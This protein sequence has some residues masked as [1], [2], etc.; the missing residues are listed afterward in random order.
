MKYSVLL[1]VI[2]CFVSHL[3]TTDSNLMSRILSVLNP[4]KHRG[5]NGK[6]LDHLPD[7][8]LASG[9]VNL[10]NTCYMNSVL[11]SLFHSPKFKTAMLKSSMSTPSFGAELQ[12]LFQELQDFKKQSNDIRPSRLARSLDVNVNIQEDAQEFLLKVLN[13]LEEEEDDDDKPSNSFKGQMIQRITCK[14]KH[15]KKEKENAFYDLSLDVSGNSNLLDSLAALFASETLD[16]YKIP[17]QGRQ[18][19]EK[20]ISIR[21]LPNTLCLHLKRF[22]FDMESGSMTKIGNPFDFPVELD[23]SPYL[24]K[25]KTVE[26]AAVEQQKQQQLK[27]DLSAVI[28]HDGTVDIGH[29][30]CYVKHSKKQWLKINDNIVETIPFSKMKEDAIGL[31]ASYGGNTASRNAYLL[32]YTS[33]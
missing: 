11:Q 10:G 24:D 16:D 2:V 27:Y 1:Y 21:Q 9:L 31:R 28:I 12:S 14:E 7:L 33:R 5:G 29:Y 22:Q 4:L 23:M 32:L 3:G 18:Q 6:A 30:Y 26:A 20:V 17:E 13:Q 25:H 19:V 8:D 15:F